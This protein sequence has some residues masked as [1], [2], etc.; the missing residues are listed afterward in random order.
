MNAERLAEIRAELENPDIIYHRGQTVRELLDHITHLEAH[1]R[2]GLDR[3]ATL[4]REAEQR[5]GAVG[6]AEL[7][8]DDARSL[9]NEAGR[10]VC[11]DQNEA[12]DLDVKLVHE[13]WRKFVSRIQLIPSSQVLQPGMVQ[14]SSEL[15][16]AYEELWD[17]ARIRCRATT[18]KEYGAQWEKINALRSQA[19][20][21][22]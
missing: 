1:N 19:G 16:S 11:G 8:D 7:T 3:I 18:E 9:I 17:M 2:D 10:R 21:E 14:I 13:L 22:G 4:E 15:L 12:S 5:G 20:G 6:M